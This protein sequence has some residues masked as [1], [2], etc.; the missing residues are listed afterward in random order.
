MILADGRRI[1][2]SLASSPL[3]THA[4]ND[5]ALFF[6]TAF[7]LSEA[8]TLPRK[9]YM[10]DLIWFSSQLAKPGGLLWWQEARGFCNSTMIDNIDRKI[11][12]GTLSEVPGGGG[13]FALDDTDPRAPR[14][15]TRLVAASQQGRALAE[16][17]RFLCSFEGTDS[18]EGYPGQIPTAHFHL[19]SG[20]S[21]E[22]SRL[23]TVWPRAWYAPRNSSSGPGKPQASPAVAMPSHLRDTTATYDA[24]ASSY[25]EK[26]RD[27][28]FDANWLRSFAEGLPE[29]SV[30][31]D[32]GSGPGRDAAVLEKLGL[33]PVCV[34]RS[35]GMLRAGTADYPNPRVMGDMLTIPVRDSSI[36]GVWANAS[37]LHL[38]P[39]EF[40]RAISE[41]VRVLIPGGK[42][43]LSLKKGCGSGWE[44]ERYGMPRWFQYWSGPDLD[45]VLER[46]NLEIARTAEETAT[47]NTW[48]VRQC[49]ART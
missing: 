40:E 8:G 19:N 24:V 42:L 13:F 14:Q 38:T 44:T 23:A 26:T 31:L 20:A 48:L 9:D 28:G 10:P 1:T 46:F 45:R 43:H 18:F 16:S 17:S 21:R 30:V 36:A 39:D 15:P 3:F 7:A 41:T 35:I 22:R 5:H 4:I 34:D 49:L 47:R 32:L 11:A 25:L 6:Q 29:R 27:Y 37:L 2:G 12:E 33:H